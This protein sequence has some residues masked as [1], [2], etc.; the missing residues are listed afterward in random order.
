MFL[1]GVTVTVNVGVT[2]HDGVCEWRRDVSCYCQE[3]MCVCL[4]MPGGVST[5][6]CL[7]CWV[8]RRVCVTML[9]DAL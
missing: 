2:C 5:F 7:S 1:Y 6:L 3:M 8:Q 4:S 9:C